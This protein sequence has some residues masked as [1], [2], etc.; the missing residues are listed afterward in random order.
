VLTGKR[1]IELSKNEFTG[2][3]KESIFTPVQIYEKAF[4][5]QK[6]LVGIFEWKLEN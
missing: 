6:K 4:P 1:N 3:F 2:P 5:S